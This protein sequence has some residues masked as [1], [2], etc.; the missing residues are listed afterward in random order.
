MGMLSYDELAG[1]GA[2]IRYRR[3]PIPRLRPRYA[4]QRKGE[5]ESEFFTRMR[6]SQ[7]KHLRPRKVSGKR[8][9]GWWRPVRPVQTRPRPVQTARPAYDPLSDPYVEQ[10]RWLDLQRRTGVWIVPKAFTPGPIM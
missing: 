10:A 6:R 3:V 5:S 7:L 1:L 8:V 4:G 2:A 9:R